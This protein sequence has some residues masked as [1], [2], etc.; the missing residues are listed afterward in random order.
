MAIILFWPECIQEVRLVYSA[1]LMVQLL[2]QLTHLPVAPL[3][4]VSELRQHCFRWWLVA[5]SAPSHYLNQCWGIVNW[6]LRNKLQWNPNRII[7]FSIHE[8][9]FENIVFKMVNILS[10]RRWVNSLWPSDDIWRQESMSTLVQVMACFS[11]TN[12]DWL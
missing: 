8:N 11:W 9:A 4:C 7:F 12:V 3:T 2:V 5:Y 6:T 1:I 10:R